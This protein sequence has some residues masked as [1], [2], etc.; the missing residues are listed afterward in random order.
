MISLLNMLYTIHVKKK[1]TVFRN[2]VRLC[3]F[4]DW[5]RASTPY[6][7]EDTSEVRA[8]PETNVTFERCCEC[9]LD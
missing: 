4:G 7:S 3:G 5:R 8:P 1:L 9:T 6:H 2:V